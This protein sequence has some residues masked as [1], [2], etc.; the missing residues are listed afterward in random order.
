MVSHCSHRCSNFILAGDYRMMLMFCCGRN[1]FFA[2]CWNDAHARE[3]YKQTIEFPGVKE[4]KAIERVGK[5]GF[6]V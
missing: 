2:I 4:F 3:V 5:Y 6:V 1:L